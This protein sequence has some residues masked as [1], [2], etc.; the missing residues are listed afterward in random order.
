MKKY[1]QRKSP[2]LEGYDYSQA[3]A[4]FVTPC[5]YK[6]K[7]WFGEVTDGK[8]QRNA[9]GQLTHEHILKIPSFYENVDIDYF[10]VMPNHL[11][12]IVII[13]DMPNIK[14][15][16]L[17]HIIGNFKGGVTR[18]FHKKHDAILWQRSFHEHIIRDE[19][20]LNRLRQ[21]ILYN[22]AKWAEDRYFE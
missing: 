14:R 13:S 16:S 2:R 17:D 5:T 12:I 9:T 8:M 3:G 21:Y 6:R 22:P 11:H 7:H 10:V 19:T 4:Y 1:P 20:D 15:Y 18:N